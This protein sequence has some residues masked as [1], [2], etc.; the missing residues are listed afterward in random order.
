MSIDFDDDTDVLINVTA[1]ARPLSTMLAR[2]FN[3]PLLLAVSLVVS[4]ISPGDQA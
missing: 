1:P 3:V 4:T 2:M